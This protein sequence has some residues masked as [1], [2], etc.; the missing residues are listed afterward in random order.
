MFT[1]D[2][3]DELAEYIKKYVGKG[4]GADLMY[5]VS[6]GRIAPSKHLIKFIAE[7]VEGN[8]IFTLLDEQRI[9]FNYII[10]L[11][12]NP[13]DRK[14]VILVNGN[15]GTGKSVV[16]VNV[17]A[18]LLKK[19]M[20]VRFVTTNAAFREAIIHEIGKTKVG[21][22]KVSSVFSRSASFVDEIQ[23][24]FPVLLV[25]EA[26]RLKSV[27]SYMYSG[28][29]GQTYDVIN[30][31]KICVLFVDDAQLIRPNDEGSTEHIKSV[32]QELNADIYEV[33]LKTQFRCSGC[34]DYI[35]WISDMLQMPGKR[36]VKNWKG[37]YEFR[38]FDDPNKMY[39]EIINLDNSGFKSR[40]LAGFAWNWNKKSSSEPDVVI[41]E[42]NFEHYW[43]DYT[44][45][46]RWSFEPN[47]RDQIGCI[48]TSQGLEFDY[49]GVII[50][51]D[52]TIGDDGKVHAVYDNYKDSVGKRGLK[53][54]P[55][56][57][58]RFVKNIY[59]I[60]M[61][62]G[63]LGCFVFCRDPKMRDHLKKAFDSL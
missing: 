37:Q 7:A 34:D 28:T 8:K 40:L 54:N 10:E 14:S 62:R 53:N 50:G 39:D 11:A 25:D 59:K 58:D 60:L 57:L 17:L 18:D 47:M 15:P 5:Q 20:N 51:N 63:T 45:S 30:A 38:I 44:N 16:A 46:I 21:E 42:F 1:K 29:K 61:T 9:A 23:N 48:H 56:E 27:G 52:L 49:V 36:D 13:G 32:A 41:E 12:N 31:A 4:K 19:G 43:N 26:H 55:L 2:E 35:D 24:K 6:N 22:T 33:T 3:Q